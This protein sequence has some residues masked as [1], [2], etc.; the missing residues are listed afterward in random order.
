MRPR[1]GP[2]TALLLLL[3]PQMAAAEANCCLQVCF[4]MHPELAVASLVAEKLLYGEV[5]RSDEAQCTLT[6]TLS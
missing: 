5:E 6:S 3:A 4:A 1:G 2:C